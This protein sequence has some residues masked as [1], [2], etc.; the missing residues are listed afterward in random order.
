MADSTKIGKRG[1]TQIAPISAVNVLVTD[2]GADKDELARL[3]DA[4][5]EVVIA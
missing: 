2:S 1:F 5:I 4:G 3:Q